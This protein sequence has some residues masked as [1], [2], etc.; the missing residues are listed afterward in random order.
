MTSAN[1]DMN[2]L[3]LYQRQEQYSNTVDSA[4]GRLYVHF[5]S[6]MIIIYPTDYMTVTVLILMDSKAVLYWDCALNF[7]GDRFLSWLL[8]ERNLFGQ[9]TFES[10]PVG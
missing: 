3:S 9:L 1:G 4:G 5:I 8:C 10:F 2:L 6:I 7:I